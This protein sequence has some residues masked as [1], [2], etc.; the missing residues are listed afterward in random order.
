[1]VGSGC[2]VGQIVI[3]AGRSAAGCRPPLILRNNE[4][5]DIASLIRDVDTPPIVGGDTIP[6]KIGRWIY[7]N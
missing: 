3:A 2:S 5:G 4:A 6:V 1:M 7:V